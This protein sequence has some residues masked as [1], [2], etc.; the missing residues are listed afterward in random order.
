MKETGG[1]HI[2]ARQIQRLVQQVGAAAQTWQEREALQPLPGT[3]PV[4][5]LYLSGDATGVPMRKEELEGR[6]GKQ[7]DGRRFCAG[8]ATRHK[9]RNR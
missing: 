2:S 1:I 8:D 7:P 3:K 4:P 6:P 9:E 5:I